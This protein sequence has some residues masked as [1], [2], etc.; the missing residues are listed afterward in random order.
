[1]HIY[2]PCA[3]LAILIGYS[4]FTFFIPGIKHR[5]RLKGVHQKLDSL[6][7][8]APCSDFAGI[9]SDDQHLLHLWNEYQETLHFQMV[10]QDGQ[11]VIASARSTVPAEMYF[12]NQSVVDGRLKTEFFKHLPGIFTG[13]GIIGTFYGIISGLGQFQVSE[14]ALTVRLSLESLMHAVGD[15]FIVSLVA[16]LAAMVST[17]G[18]KFLLASLYGHSE[19]IAIA[20]DK[21]FNSGVGEEYLARLVKASEESASQSKI[22]KDALVQE[23]GDLLREITNAQI[24]AAQESNRQLGGVIASSIKDSL[25]VPLHDIASTVKAASG[26]QSSSAVAMLQDVMAS[27][28]QRLNDLF[29]GQINGINDLNK[30]TAQTMQEAVNSLHTLVSKLEDSSKRSTDDMATQMASA[31]KS[32]EERQMAINAQTQGF[33]EQIRA[34]VENTQSETQQKLQATLESIGQQMGVMLD[35]LN[36]TQAKASEENRQREHSMAENAKTMASEMAG[37]MEA[38]VREMVT[39]SQIMAESV[40]TLTQAT[41]SSIDK[42]SAGAGRMDNAASNFATAGERVS[43]IMTQVS[44]ISGKLE[45]IS[46]SLMSGSGALQDALHDYRAQREAV[47]QML[48]EIRTTVELARKEASITGDVLKR[49]EDSAAALGVAQKD[50]GVYLDGVSHVLAESS[51]AFRESVVSTLAKVNHDFHTKLASAVGMLSAAIQ[52]LEVSLGSIT[53]KK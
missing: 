29:G 31:M 21:H 12:N 11:M 17:L 30:Q 8:G 40:S 51:D 19:R 1:M 26:E 41:S 53:V 28:S 13:I 5:K 22:L 23:L 2:L 36:A 35:N 4:V 3:F 33:V 15:A 44:T 45:V 52:E 48:A 7:E 42:L 9:F 34:L 38:A 49:I 46:G 37:T 16:I 32:M 39:A 20:I 14:N 6:A 27:F 43:D 10:E 24:G 25:E 50:A 47:T 18:E